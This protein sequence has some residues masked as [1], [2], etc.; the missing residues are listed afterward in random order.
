MVDNNCDGTVDE[1]TTTTYYADLDQDGYGDPNITAD[2]CTE[3]LPTPA[4][5]DCDD[6]LSSVNPDGVE[7]SILDDCDGAADAEFM[8]GLVYTEYNCGFAEMTVPIMY[9][10]A[11][12]SCDTTPPVLMQLQLRCRLCGC[13][14]RCSECLFS[15][16]MMPLMA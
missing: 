6:S 1:G 7:I 15:R 4:M 5:T 14:R 2:A 3:L 11:T 8:T 12:P 16:V 13:Q 10:N 9:L